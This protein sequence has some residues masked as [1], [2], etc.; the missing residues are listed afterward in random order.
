MQ[1]N[2]SPSGAKKSRRNETVHI[3]LTISKVFLKRI[4]EAAGRD[5]TTRSD[6]IRVALL[7]YLR[8]E[9][10][11]LDHGD[12]DAIFKTL[13]QRHAQVELRKMIKDIEKG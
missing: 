9:G 3:N 2:M 1:K 5:Y 7:W 11:E 13:K 6:I 10:R 12:P 4:D 8:P